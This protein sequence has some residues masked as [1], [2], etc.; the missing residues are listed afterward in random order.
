MKDPDCV[1]FL[2]WAL[3]RMQMRWPGF[4]KVRRQVCKRIDRRLSEL[5]LA[6]VSAYREYLQAHQEEW[7]V[8]DSFCRIPISRFYRDRGVFDHLRD[9][10]L[11]GLATMARAKGDRSLQCWSAGC[12]SGEEVYTVN[13]LWMLHLGS[14][15]PDLQLRIT[16]TDSDPNML[17]RARRGCYPASSLKDIPEDWLSAAFKESGRCWCLKPEFRNDI[18]FAQQDL[19]HDVPAGR[20]HLVL[21]RHL[22]FTYFDGA[23]QRETLAR[24]LTKL[25]PG[26]ILVTGKQEPLPIQLAELQACEPQMGIYRKLG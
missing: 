8:L 22:A 3:P 20:F 14:R 10:I 13:L 25:V 5:R 12:A 1:Q 17:D 21:C 15:F 16:A 4:R 7:S 23:L 19:R 26:G 11:P 18:A 2:Q 9:H 6:D 24:I